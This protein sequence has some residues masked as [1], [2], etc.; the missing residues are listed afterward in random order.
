MFK[1]NARPRFAVLVVLALV[2]LLTRSHHVGGMNFLPDASW[3]IFFLA[4]FYCTSIWSAPLL[5][6]AAA[7]V[8]LLAIQF[9][10]VNGFCVTP[11][12][13]ALI[14]AYG[15]LY[16]AGRGFRKIYQP[17]LASLLTGFGAAMGGALAAELFSSGGF[18][19]FSGYFSQPTPAG[20]AARLLKYFPATV[21][22]MTLYLVMAAAIHILLVNLSAGRSA[23]LHGR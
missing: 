8:D 5:M 18:Y 9:G 22:V 19:L 12:Y 16:L 17:T 14:P 7:A 3:A 13:W 15:S 4:G 10:G 20:F 1:L 6:L 11:A 21:E 2:M 23:D